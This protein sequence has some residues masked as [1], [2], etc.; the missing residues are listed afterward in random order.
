MSNASYINLSR[1]SGLLSELQTVANNIANMS[2]TGYRREGVI[3]S[4][5]VQN[6]GRGNDSISMADANG[7]LTDTQQGALSETGSIFDFAIEGP[8]YFQLQTP[9]GPRLTRAGS[10][11]PNEQGELVSVD[12][13]QLLDLGSAPIFVPPNAGSITLAPDGTISAD[14][15]PLAQIG[16]F[17]TTDQNSLTREG[18]VMFRS[19]G[20]I[21]PIEGSILVQGF[22]EGSNVSPITETARLIEVQRSYELGQKFLEREDERIRA[23]VRTLG[24]N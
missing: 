7:R 22:L 11:T 2:T 16:I 12:G 20:D 24:Q 21:L 5:Y 9:D 1:Q 13:Y 14:E 17:E 6:T 15:N 10:F 3:F 8:G 4:E 23:V 18:G 19:D